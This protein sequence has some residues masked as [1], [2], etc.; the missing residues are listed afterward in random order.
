MI[1]VK[2]SAKLQVLSV[3]CFKRKC[4]AS[5]CIDSFYP[6]N[7]HIFPHSLLCLVMID[8]Y[9]T[10]IISRPAS[11]LTMC[12]QTNFSSKIHAGLK[13]LTLENFVCKIFLIFKWSSIF[14]DIL[15]F[16]KFLYRIKLLMVQK[17]V[18][19]ILYKNWEI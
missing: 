3:L 1:C 9:L 11:N 4:N 18:V 17:Y 8:L 2:I 15:I 7:F 13:N 6:C 19:L 12:F 5:K 10:L 14:R 16:K